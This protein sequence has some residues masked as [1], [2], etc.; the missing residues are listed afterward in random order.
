MWAEISEKLADLLD[1]DIKYGGGPPSVQRFLRTMSSRVDEMETLI[2]LRDVTRAAGKLTALPQE[3]VER[4]NEFDRK[5]TAAR[6]ELNSIHKTLTS[7]PT[8]PN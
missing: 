1:P 6:D 7:I 8:R 2:A 4:L 3:L 5:I